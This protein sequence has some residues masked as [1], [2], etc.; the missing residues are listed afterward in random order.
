MRLFEFAGF[1]DEPEGVADDLEATLLGVISQLRNR[2]HDFG[3]IGK[4]S[5]EAFINLVHKAGVPFNY[6]I[7]VEKYEKS[8]ALKNNIATISRDEITFKDFGDEVD[9]APDEETPDIVGDNPQAKVAQMA[10]RALTNR[11]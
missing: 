1:E 8:K 6:K 2:S 5:T 11:S 3:H 7:F 4:F 10:N 9:A